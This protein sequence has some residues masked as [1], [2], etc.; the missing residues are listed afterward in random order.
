MYTLPRALYSTEQWEPF[1]TELYIVYTPPFNHTTTLHLCSTPSPHHNTSSLLNP[2]SSPQ[3]VIPAQPHLFT[4]TLHPCST[5]SL[6]HNTSS[7]LNPISSPQHFIPAQPHLLTTTLH[8]CSTP[9]SHDTLYPYSA[10]NLH[11]YFQSSFT[12]LIKTFGSSFSL[13]CTPKYIQNNIFFFSS[14]YNL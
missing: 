4:T 3:H 9:S 13:L 8:L 11:L 12:F 14:H 6:H 10:P 2:I 5:P 7:L 1:S